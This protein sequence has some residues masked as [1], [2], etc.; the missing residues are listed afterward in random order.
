MKFLRP[1]CLLVGLLA[2]AAVMYYLGPKALEALYGAIHIEFP[3][4][5]STNPFVTLAASIFGASAG[6][7][8][9]GNWL[10]R[11]IERSINNWDQLD[12]GHKVTLFVGT[13]V[14]VIIT[15]PFIVLFLSQSPAIAVPLSIGMLLLISAV[16]IFA[17]KSMEDILPWSKN[18]GRG[19]RSNYKIL[20]TNIII[21]GRIFDIV[22]TGFLDGRL[23]IPGFVLNELQHIADNG[24]NLKRQ[25]G[26]RGLDILQQLKAKFN[27]EVGTL[28]RR[29]TDGPDG[30]DGR[31]VRLARAIGGDLVTNDHNL[32]RVAE[33]Q[34]VRVININELALALRP[35]VLP[36]ETLEILVS[37]EGSQ[38]NQGVGYLDDGT[39]VVIENGR[40]LVGETVTTRVTQVHQTE[41]G[42]MIFADVISEADQREQKARKPQR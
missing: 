29:S 24:D 7:A 6:A 38:Y 4:E 33:L 27:V 14:G 23:Y 36:S 11:L 35:T 21:D 17:L 3:G 22:R 15:S 30:V 25:R 31:L 32:N 5:A 40:R 18:K 1:S 20:D 41:R 2:G 13:T 9:V 34:G 42:K 26:K 16:C 28:D 10:N 39:M 37:R 19:S 12:S 8:T